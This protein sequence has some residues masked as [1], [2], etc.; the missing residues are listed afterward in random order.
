M[1]TNATVPPIK[2]EYAEAYNPDTHSHS[3]DL[4]QMTK[5]NLLARAAE[6]G[7][8]AKATMRKGEL[9]EMIEAA[10]GR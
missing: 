7:I 3:T 6:L 2:V 10:E 5:A 9:I 1:V 8:E 4:C